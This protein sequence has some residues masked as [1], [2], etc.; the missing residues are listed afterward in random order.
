M[1][2]PRFGARGA[3]V[4]TS[5]VE[6]AVMIATLIALPKD[7]APDH[8]A[9]FGYVGR[10]LDAD[11]RT[12]SAPTQAVATRRRS[13]AIVVAAV[14]GAIVLGV[15]LVVYPTLAFAGAGLGLFVLLWFGPRWALLVVPAL[16]ML[17]SDPVLIQMTGAAASRPFYLAMDAWTLLALVA[18]TV[19]ALTGDEQA[20]QA[21]RSALGRGVVALW[22]AFGVAAVLGGGSGADLGTQWGD[23]RGILY[24]GWI[25]VAAYLFGS[26]R[27]RGAG[28]LVVLTASAVA[29]KGLVFYA[30][31]IGLR[32]ASYV[33]GYRAF[34]SEETTVGLILLAVG[35]AVM[36]NPEVKRWAA[37]LSFTVGIV[38][39]LLGSLRAYWLASALVVVVL[40]AI[41][42]FTSPTRSVR[43]VAWLAAAGGVVVL[44]LLT[45]ARQFYEV[46]VAKRLETILGGARAAQGD[47]SLGYRFVEFATVNE[48]VGR[49]I[50]LG[51][52]L[53]A[54]HRGVLIYDPADLLQQA[55]LPG[56]VHNSFLWSYLKAGLVGVAGAVAYYAGTI[57]EPLRTLRKGPSP[58]VRDVSL[59][60]A[61]VAGALVFVGLFN[62]LI[63]SA[64]Y[65]I[66]VALAFGWYY[67]FAR[68]ADLR[69][70]PLDVG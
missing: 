69:E 23:A 12:M 50:L 4:V 21:F 61:V 68:R 58:L 66:V 64:R 10:R 45:V 20:R 38:I 57:I 40:V 48:A 46:T 39:V 7:V 28:A 44:A 36:G 47:I 53:G 6:V 31:G 41:Q 13:S 33:A 49:R 60:F 26:T 34:G 29:L 11:G 65:E 62:A 8:R 51:A 19:T 30:T 63:T 9:G 25:L 15:A 55:V 2:I 32:G 22:L 43:T 1:A 52:G 3:A 67:G 56:Y 17:A 70:E 35:L 27:S 18:V 24:A 5:V 14:L 16:W 37:Y 59:A 54:T 42:V